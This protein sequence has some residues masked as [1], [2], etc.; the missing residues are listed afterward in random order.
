MQITLTSAVQPRWM[1]AGHTRINLQVQFE[2]LPEMVEFTASPNDIEP[3]GRLIFERAA[4]GEYGEVAEYI[5]PTPLEVAARDNPPMRRNA[6][7]L[8]TTNVQHFEMMG[9]TEQ[10]ATWRGYYQELYALEQVPEWPL[11]EQWPTAPALAA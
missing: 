4:A 3:H 2:H 9:D 8:A 11:V 1:D 7:A 5:P 6:M 10:A